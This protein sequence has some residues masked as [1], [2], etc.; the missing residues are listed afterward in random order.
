MI[1]LY[2]LPTSSRHFHIIHSIIGNNRQ[3]KRALF[4]LV[5]FYI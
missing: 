5:C 4:S 2:F 1:A 3:M